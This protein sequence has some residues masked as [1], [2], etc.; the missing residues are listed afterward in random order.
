MM[1][2][3][4]PRERQ[5]LDRG[6]TQERLIRAYKGIEPAERLKDGAVR[7]IRIS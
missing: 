2:S 4:R 5:R 1:M 6:V 7:L 3:S